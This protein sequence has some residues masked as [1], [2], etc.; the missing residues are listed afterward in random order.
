MKSVPGN[1]YVALL[2]GINV[3]GSNL[4]KMSDLK[5]CLAAAGLR[6]VTTYIQSGNVLFSAGRSSQPALVRQVENSLSARFAYQSR[7]VVRSFNQ[8]R[9]VVEGA[10]AG[11][12]KRP[13][14][15]RYDVIFLKEPLT[16]AE[17]L[18]SVAAKPGVDEV[19]AGDGVLYFARLISKA[20][21]SHLSRIVGTPAYQSM[22][23]RNWN[24]TTRLLA[25]MESRAVDSSSR[26]RSA[27]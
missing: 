4:I 26:R 14:A 7:V 13:A 17:A 27:R 16:A 3:G 12:G 6:E 21:Q 11:F 1:R 2:R 20:T 25:L 15:Y 18:K 8:M 19:F 9:A 5:A 24:T 10:P 22:T 23:I